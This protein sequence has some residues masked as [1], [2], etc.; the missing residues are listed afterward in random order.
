MK[1]L[2]VVVP[3]RTGEQ[4]R[5]LLSEGGWL[6]SDLKID[7]DPERVAFPVSG[8]PKAPIPDALTEEREF[9]VLRSA[10]A[11][12][13]RDLVSLPA[14]EK[15]LLPRAFDVIGDL[16]VIRLPKELEARGTQIGEALLQFVPGARLVGLDRGV[17]GVERR[18]SL[19]R[20]AGTGPWTT[21]HAENGLTL[22]VDLQ[23]AYFSPR[24]AREHARVASAVAQGERVFDLCCGVGSFSLTIARDGKAKEIVAVD[25]NPEAIALGRSSAQRL[26]LSDRI[27]FES[28]PVEQF[29]VGAGT[30]DRV[31][32]N[33][34]REGIKYL[35]QV[36]TTVEPG[37]SLYYYEVTEV[38]QEGRRPRELVGTLEGAGGRWVAV[39]DR[40]VHPY[41]PTLDLR[42]YEMQRTR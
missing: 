32:F 20:L 40:R 23:R 16:V 8:Y 25:L 24:L 19:E 1:S 21:R 7:A 12:S 28:V 39:R 41:A 36:G 14:P 35:P 27:R 6:R 42:V 33:L 34:P 29:V 2:A 13:Y 37:G 18:R 31:I 38:E 10:S 9:R 26:G 3:R 30:A 15:G 4:T 11:R 5:R 17:Q 22:D